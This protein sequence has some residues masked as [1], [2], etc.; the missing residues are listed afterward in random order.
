MSRHVPIWWKTFDCSGLDS[1]DIRF[2][3]TTYHVQPTLLANLARSDIGKYWCRVPKKPHTMLRNSWHLSWKKAILFLKWF[4]QHPKIHHNYTLP[5]ISCMI[6]NFWCSQR[7]PPHAKKMWKG[8]EKRRKR[9]YN[10][11]GR[12]EDIK[13]WSKSEWGRVYMHCQNFF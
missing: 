3:E 12:K 1:K 5:R 10:E 6:T 11:R 2:S 4:R 13:W 7:E 9:K 8:K